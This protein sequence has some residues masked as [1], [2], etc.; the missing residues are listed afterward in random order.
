MG[1][2]NSPSQMKGAGEFQY[3]L[4]HSPKRLEQFTLVPT[5]GAERSLLI[6]PGWQPPVTGPTW[7]VPTYIQT[8]L[9]GKMEAKGVGSVD[10]AFVAQ[11]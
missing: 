3:F 6:R 4:E 8:E 1:R 5:P 10:K 2:N 7:L 11:A 9:R